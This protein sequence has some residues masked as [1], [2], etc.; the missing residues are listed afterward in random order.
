IAHFS[1]EDDHVRM[2]SNGFIEGPVH[3]AT[4]GRYRIGLWARGSSAK[5][6]YPIV[7]VTLDGKELGRVEC[8]GA[9]W[10]EHAIVADLAEGDAVLRLAFI[11]D[12]YEPP[13]DRNLWLDRVEFQLVDKP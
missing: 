5:G 7:V 12:Y 6:T 1:R 8:I 13:E 10:G 4:P 3:I 9:E 2:G 11:N